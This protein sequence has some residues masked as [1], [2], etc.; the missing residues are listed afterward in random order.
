[1]YTI[2]FECCRIS[3]ETL[4]LLGLNRSAD[5]HRCGRLY[6]ALS[7]HPG[8]S[9]IDVGE[10]TRTVCKYGTNNRSGLS[11]AY[12]CAILPNYAVFRSL[13]SD[14][15]IVGRPTKNHLVECNKM[16]KVISATGIGLNNILLREL[17]LA[18]GREVR[19]PWN[20]KGYRA[21]GCGSSPK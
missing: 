16:M 9:G 11:R 13:D 14:V 2:I 1:M 15:L 5:C 17:R 7:N 19:N 8:W 21:L 3:S 20:R 6:V 12:R 10:I 18:G 4:L